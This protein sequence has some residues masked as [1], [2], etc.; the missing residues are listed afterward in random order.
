MKANS[1]T[2]NRNI[3]TTNGGDTTFLV[4][5]L[6]ISNEIPKEFI[7]YQNYPNPFNPITKLK[8]QMSKKGFVQLIVYDITGK[9]VI[10]L[11][12]EELSAGTYE[13]DFAPESTGLHI[14]SGV[15]FYQLNVL[16]SGSGR[17]EVFTETKKMLLI[18]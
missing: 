5:L 18:K 9:Q 14:S 15:Y 13:T 3:H 16:T 7:L 6:Q 10:K 4:G 2:E 12:S 8:F 17:K 1:S 11:I